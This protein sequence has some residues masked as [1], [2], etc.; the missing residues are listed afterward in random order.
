MEDRS[1]SVVLSFTILGLRSLFWAFYLETDYHCWKMVKTW[2]R[3]V[4][5]FPRGSYQRLRECVSLAVQPSLSCDHAW[6]AWSM[7]AQFIRVSNLTDVLT[8]ASNWMVSANKSNGKKE[9]RIQRII[10]FFF[11]LG[12]NL[13]RLA[14]WYP[15]VNAA[16]LEAHTILHM[17]VKIISVKMMLCGLIR[18]KSSSCDYRWVI[19]CCFTVFQ[20]FCWTS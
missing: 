3:P 13:C 20:A 1:S 12:L 16:L 8:E 18:L 4:S 10:F 15:V 11:F 17:G 7:M 2:L 14:V 19:V 6:H 9:K 5:S